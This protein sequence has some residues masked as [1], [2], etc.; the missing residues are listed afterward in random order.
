MP[1]RTVC[2]D[3]V[4]AMSLSAQPLKRSFG[5]IV[6]ADTRVLL[7]GS[8]PGEKSL[9]RRQYYAHPQN[10]FWRLVGAVLDVE[11]VSLAYPERLDMLLAKRVGLWDV[12]A[13]ARR[14]GSGDGAIR[15]AAPNLL[16][17][18]VASL[19]ELRAV[20]FNGGKAH[21]IGQ[22]Q[23][24]QLDGV[25]LLALPSSSPAYTIPFAQKLTAWLE[26]RRYL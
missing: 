7:L 1:P 19:P 23:L 9:E 13:S 15:D 11:L 5:A 2:G 8:L 24:G 21:A 17:E 3:R 22:R 4:R 6:A 26:L 14:R 25:A 16:G 12:V 20:G 18:L 10:Q